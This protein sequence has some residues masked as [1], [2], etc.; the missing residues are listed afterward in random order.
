MEITSLALALVFIVIL[1]ILFY[2]GTLSSLNKQPD[3]PESA[4]ISLEY[5]QV[6]RKDTRKVTSGRGKHK[7]SHTEYNI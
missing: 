5:A 1:G 4:T 2:N 6:T 3:D 7:T